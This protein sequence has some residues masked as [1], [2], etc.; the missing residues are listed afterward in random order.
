MRYPAQVLRPLKELACHPHAHAWGFRLPGFRI[1]A[2]HPVAALI[3]FSAFSVISFGGIPPYLA[4]KMAR[5][6]ASQH[7]IP[8]VFERDHNQFRAHG[9]GFVLN[10]SSTG[11]RLQWTNPETGKKTEVVTRLPGAKSTVEPFTRLPGETN[12]FLGNRANWRTGV[13]AWEGVRCREAYPGIDLVFH[14]DSA[15]LEYDFVV[16]PSADPRQIR[17]EL[18]GQKTLGID[19]HG[20]LIVSTSAGEIRWKHPE[21]YQD[22]EGQRRPVD[23]KFVLSGRNT[24]RFETG[25][26]DA[27]RELV[28]DPT[29]AYSTYLGGNGNDTARGVA[30]DASGNVYICGETTSTNLPIL[31]AFQTTHAPQGSMTLGDVFVAKFNSAGGLVY[32]TYL[33]GSGD[34]VGLSIAV[35]ASGNAYI[36]GYT[37]SSNF[38]I[39]G[40]SPF[41]STYGGSGGSTW[42]HTGDAFVTKLNPSG[43][44]L[45]Y[46]TYLGGSQDEMAQAITIDSSGDAYV[47][48]ATASLNFP[49]ITGSYQTSL[50]G[51]GG[52][53]I[54]PCCTGPFVDPGDAFVVE[55]NPAGSKLVVSTLIGGTDDDAAIAIAL[56]SSA[57]IY[58]AGYTMSEDF[59]VTQGSLQRYWGGFDQQTP[60]FVTGDGFIVKLNPTGTALQYSTYFGGGGDECITSIAVDPAGDLYF[61]GWSSTM[62]LPTTTGAAQST[63]AGYQILPS[64]IEYN[65]GDAIAGKLNPAGSALIYLTYL[66]GNANDAGLGIGIDSAGDAFVAGFTDSTNFPVTSNAV[67]TKWGGDVG[68]TPPYLSFGD[69]FLTMLNPVGGSF[70]YSSLLGGAGNDEFFG[71]ALNGAGTAYVVGNTYSTNFPVTSNAF[72]PKYGGYS[73]VY[74]W[75][76]GDAAY[77][78]FSGFPTTPVV[79]KVANAEGEVAVIAP[80]TWVEIKGSGLAPDA[81][82][83]LASDFVANQ[84]PTSLD[85]TSVTVNGEK[86]FVYYISPTQINILTPP[87][88]VAGTAQV[89]VNNQGTPSVPVAATSQAYSTSFFVFNGG[90]YVVATHT[91]GSLI[92]P[93]TLYPG[94]STP[95]SAGE[96]IIIYANGFGSVTPAVVS[97][98]ATQS[99]VLPALPTIY[100]GANKATVSFAG[101]I[102][103]G[104]Y[105]FNV[106]VP[107]AAV[108]GDNTITATFYGN[109]TQAGTLLTIK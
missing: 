95:A 4:S 106:Q 100:I 82:T 49:T 89:V 98:S 76:W 32:L 103:P 17:M 36:A 85:S 79:S 12:Y 5:G 50:R 29:L 64:T 15:S 18:T 97:G 90:P 43:N 52:E 60:Y 26:Y 102:S 8:L 11:N 104:L 1:A 67:Q 33:G 105:Q 86:A 22:V 59:P 69:G 24:V 27:S 44:G 28:I 6:G 99:G 39:A 73:S 65:F 68:Q 66:G 87:D 75:P 70:L 80:N 34:D 46:S 93:T 14:G 2:H 91:N 38:P 77:S 37:T 92:G 47:A 61:T 101:L 53:P 57:N 20:D 55:I 40:S 83:W 56:D 19:A 25:A 42:Y 84:M 78:V 54:E 51:L 48:G 7:K 16:K 30:V 71:L 10:V 23:G 41:Q 81:R 74:D 108:S 35:D 9:Q 96:T 21:L 63:Y 58:I 31:S 72:Q 109:T 88:L 94:S 62:N 107:S 3:L 13:E 45:V